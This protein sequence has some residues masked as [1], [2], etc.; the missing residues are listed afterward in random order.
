ML[1][2][3]RGI[4]VVVSRSKQEPPEALRSAKFNDSLYRGVG[5]AD[6]LHKNWNRITGIPRVFCAKTR[7]L[8]IFLQ[9]TCVGYSVEVFTEI[10]GTSWCPL[11]T[12]HL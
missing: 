6:C 5:H 9:F 10:T 1:G 12:H 4:N 2:W 3:I 11:I 8:E 7:G